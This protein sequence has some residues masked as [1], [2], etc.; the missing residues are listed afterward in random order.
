MPG[1][2]PIKTRSMQGPSQD[3]KSGRAGLGLLGKKLPKEKEGKIT[4]IMVGERW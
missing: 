4:I 1:Q 2:D 3:K